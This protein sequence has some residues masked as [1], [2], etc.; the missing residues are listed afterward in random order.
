MLIPGCSESVGQRV[1]HV[2]RQFFVYL[3]D[4]TLIQHAVERGALLVHER[5]GRDMLHLQCERMVD[6]VL[7]LV[8][9]LS[10]KPEYQVYTHISDSHCS[11]S[12]HGLVHLSGAVTAA[13]ELQSPVIEGLC[14]HAHPV[15]GCRQCEV[16]TANI[17]WI[18]LD[19][20][21]CIWGYGVHLI[22]IMKQELQLLP[23]ECAG[24]ASAQIHRLYL[25]R[26]ERPELHLP[27]QRFYVPLAQR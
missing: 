8:E 12:A 25:S 14:A 19:G 7:P 18:A 3:L 13:D 4:G 2:E 9:R 24:R 17:V 1:V 26:G 15:D 20:H 5:V 27:A 6:I 11:Q 22:Y 21:F 16:W 23:R 10:R